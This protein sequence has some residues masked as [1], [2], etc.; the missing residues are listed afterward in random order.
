[1]SEEEGEGEMGG[2][3]LERM[4]TCGMVVRNSDIMA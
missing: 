4:C 2:S 1:M 3:I